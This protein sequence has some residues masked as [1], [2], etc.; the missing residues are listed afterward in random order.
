MKRYT[1]LLLALLA[2]A[3]TAHAQPAPRIFSEIL[4]DEALNR[5]RANAPVHMRAILVKPNAPTDTALMM[6][7]GSPGY[8]KIESVKD[9]NRNYANFV[10]QNEVLF[11]REGIALVVMDCPT[12]Q[13][14]EY[15]GPGPT[16]CF[17][18]YRSSKAHA[19]DVRRIMAVLREQHGYSKF[20]VLGHSQGTVSS[21]WMAKQLGNE[22]E[23]SIHSASINVANPKGY[24]K[25]MRDFPYQSITTPM[26][27]IHNEKD[28]CSGTPYKLVQAYAGENLITVRGGIPEGEP[29]GA[30]HLHSHQGREEVVAKT[31]I[32]WI[33]TRQVPRVIGE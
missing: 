29:C 14:G 23:G 7:R 32:G 21:R 24:A 25:S 17:D 6:F 8:A 16:N 20:Y 11:I 5:T 3:S 15:G 1:I 19:D 10:R 12:D 9:K 33:K 26:I 2:V 22:I 30:G 18:D 28:A 4:I 27:H 31:V 13:W